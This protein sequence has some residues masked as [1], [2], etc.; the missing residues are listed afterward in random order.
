MTSRNPISAASNYFKQSTAGMPLPKATMFLRKPRLAILDQVWS[1]LK[2]GRLRRSLE[3]KHKI[4][5]TI[6]ALLVAQLSRES[7]G[8][9]NG[10]GG[11]AAI[12]IRAIFAGSPRYV[13]VARLNRIRLRRTEP[14]QD[15]IAVDCASVSLNENAARREMD[16]YLPDAVRAA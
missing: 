8:S 2:S 9:R 10:P 4:D 6:C 3:A 16:R 15:R 12:P 5:I 11:L 14:E 1:F 13:R 7:C